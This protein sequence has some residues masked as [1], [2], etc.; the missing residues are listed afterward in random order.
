MKLKFILSL[1]LLLTFVNANAHT[2]ASNTK[3]S[4]RVEISMYSNDIPFDI[5]TTGE[6]DGSRSAFPLIPIV[7]FLEETNH[8]IVLD[9]IKPIGVVKVT[10]S[11]NGV[12]AYSSLENIQDATLNIINL[13]PELFGSFLLEIEGANS[14]CIY[15][16]FSL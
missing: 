4:A 11:Q 1:L 12:V 10:I 16:D 6:E 13:S 8:S 14:A 3:T 5:L 15:G 7:V 9:F 2:L